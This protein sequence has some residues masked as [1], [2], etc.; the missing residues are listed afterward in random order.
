ME[1]EIVQFGIRGDVF[2]NFITDLLTFGEIKKSFIKKLTTEESLEKYN[3][4]FTSKSINCDENYEYYE[5]LGDASI[6]LFI[7]SYSYRRFPQ[8][9]RPDGIRFAARIKA[10]YAGCQELAKISKLYNF[11][12]FITCTKSEKKDSLY[13]DVFES[14]IGVTQD[15]IDEQIKYENEDIFGIGYTCVYRL[16]KN[17]YDK[18]EI[19]LEYE[20][21]FDPKTR[22][23]EIIQIN[24]NI[25]IKYISSRD[26]EM[27]KTITKGILKIGNSEQQFISEAEIKIDSEQKV[28]EKIIDF[29][30]EKNIERKTSKIYQ[31]IL[32]NQKSD[33]HKPLEYLLKDKKINDELKIHQFHGPAIFYYAKHRDLLG[34][35]E[36]FDKKADLNI[37]Y[38][39]FTLVDKILLGKNDKDNVKK[40][41]DFVT[42]KTQKLYVSTEIYEHYKKIYDLDT[43]IKI[44][45]K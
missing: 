45:K 39:N 30:K 27:K 21:L 38:E 35:K 8:I 11:E 32:T 29:L 10:L 1:K 31:D 22:L 2:K 4:A 13:E 14:F 18:I 19:S 36:C 12:K 7:V 15:L 6:G 25:E 16:L 42:S 20:K 40:C 26:Q 33:K 23:N 24:K 3:I 34:I 17:I 44:V 5:Q 28:A 37:I 9:K 41:L 43:Y